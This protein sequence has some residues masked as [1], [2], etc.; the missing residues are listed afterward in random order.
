M[1]T[2]RSSTET[3]I[4]ALRVLSRD[5]VTDDGVISACLR[6]AAGRMEEMQRQL[7][8]VPVEEAKLTAG[9]LFWNDEEEEGYTDAFEALKGALDGTQGAF[10]ERIQRSKRLPDAFAVGELTEDGFEDVKFFAT[11]DEA[12]VEFLAR[13]LQSG[14]GL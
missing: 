10:I 1:I 5:I 3:I 14:L 4:G 9:D 2:P 13:N 8:R 6:E 12:K 11:A 7:E